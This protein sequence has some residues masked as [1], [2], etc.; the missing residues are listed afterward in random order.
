MRNIDLDYELMPFLFRS[1]SNDD[2]FLSAVH[3]DFYWLNKSVFDSLLGQGKIQDSNIVQDLL[4]RQFISVDLSQSIDVAA[5]KLRS[6]KIF[7]RDFTS[8]HMLVTT[9]RCNQHCEYCQVSCEGDDAVR[10]DMSKQVATRIVDTIFQTPSNCIKIEF[11]GGEPTLNW[12]IIPH[13]IEYAKE[14]NKI[15]RKKVDFVV[16]TNLTTMNAEKFEYLS[17]HDVCISTSLDGPPPLHD[18]CRKQRIGTSSHQLFEK[19]LELGRSIVGYD[20]IDALMTTSRYSLNKCREIID[21]YV[22]LG[23]HGIFLR[24]LNPYGFA[25]EQASVLGYSVQEFIEFYKN[26]LEYILEL[27]SQG[28]V[29]TEYYTALLFKRIM[30]SQSTGFVDLQSPSGAGISGIIYDYNGDV[31]P[32]DE[33]R[34]LAR[35]GDQRFLMGNVIDHGFKEIFNGYVLREI[36]EN[37]CLETIPG[38]SDCVYSPYCGADPIRNYLEYGSLIGKNPGS[39]FCQK[40]MAIFDYIFGKIKEKDNFFLNTV[41]SWITPDARGLMYENV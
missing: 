4:S 13:V 12:D 5:T 31:Y 23:F 37:T 32:A 24:S 19:N 2:I 33:G 29:F 15:H 8:L 21:E 28:T 17:N 39:N 18:V 30:T 26:C 36:V 25:S 41:W 34:M 7:L 1:E 22:R 40:N 14:I 35:M 3:G 10:F 20:K 6:R 16:C 38:C 27:N 9:L 11:Q